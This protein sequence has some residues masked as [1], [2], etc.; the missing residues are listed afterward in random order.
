MIDVIYFLYFN[1]HLLHFQLKTN[2][3]GIT[4]VSVVSM[5]N[6]MSFIQWIIT[7]Y[8]TNGYKLQIICFCVHQHCMYLILLL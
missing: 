5:A 1:Y 6:N 3:F 8:Y 4:E 7:P 2:S